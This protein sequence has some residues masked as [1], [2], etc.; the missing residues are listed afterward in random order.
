MIV[1]DNV[2]MCYSCDKLFC[3]TCSETNINCPNC[4]TKLKQSQKNYYIE[5]Q[6]R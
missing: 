1:K 5:K 3:K 6:Y 4:N 2:D